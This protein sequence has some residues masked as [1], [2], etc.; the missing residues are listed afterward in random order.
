M[1]KGMTKRRPETQ[2]RML[3]AAVEAFVELGY[4]GASIGEICKRAGYTT[5]AFYS[6][7]STKDELFYA[8][9]DAHA[10]KAIDRIADKLAAVDVQ[11]LTLEQFAT[12]LADV[13]PEERTWFIISTEFTLYAVRTPEA[14][15]VLAAHEAKVRAALTPILEIVLTRAGAEHHVDLDSFARL[16]IALREGALMQSLVEPD[17][18]PPG[19]LERRYLP[20]LIRAAATQAQAPDPANG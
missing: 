19:T 2:A 11:T 13:G 14:A 10:A 20:Q 17:E 15:R 4:T 1:P 9:F 6:N 5:G 8:L 16:A 7:W 12:H 3:D 18:L